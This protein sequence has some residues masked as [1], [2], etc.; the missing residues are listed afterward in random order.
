MILNTIIGFIMPWI[1]SLTIIR[2]HKVI[3][4]IAP[5]A[6]VVSFIIDD[7]GFYFF[8][9]LYPFELTNLSAVPFNI[10]LFCLYPCVSIELIRK[11]EIKPYIV[12]LGMAL[13]IT[14]ME[15]CG[16]LVGRVIYYNGWNVIATYFSYLLALVIS[17]R[18]YKILKK[19]SLI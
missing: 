13:M 5:F 19:Q 3:Y 15:Y 16:I 4:Y 8:W 6:S 10:G 11:Y 14:L 12:I 9:N 17:Y 1:I 2:G 7:L 18:F